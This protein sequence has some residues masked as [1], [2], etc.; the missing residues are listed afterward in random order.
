MWWKPDRLVPILEAE[1]K[2]Q[3]QRY[4]RRQQ[5]RLQNCTAVVQ[6]DNNQQQTKRDHCGLGK[7]PGV[8]GGGRDGR[9][10]ESSVVEDG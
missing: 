1:L 6:P 8:G 7:A 5:D 3:L 10:G 2:N 9:K 4:Q